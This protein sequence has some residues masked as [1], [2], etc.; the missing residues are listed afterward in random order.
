MH[1]MGDF[2]VLGGIGPWDGLAD[3]MDT[4]FRFLPIWAQPLWRLVLGVAVAFGLMYLL[5]F[6]LRQTA[7]KVAAVMHTTAKEAMSQPLFYVVLALGI[8]ALLMFPFIPYNTLGED[9]KMLKEVGLDLI[10]VLAIIVG[11]WAASV[12][13]ADEIEGRTA[14]TLLSKPLGRRQMIIG[15]FLGVVWPVAVLFIIF[16]VIFLGTISYKVKYDARESSNPE[17]VMGDC[18]N[19]F[20]SS[21]P[22][23]ALGFMK[24]VVL[25]S[26]SVAVSTRLPFL[27][28]IVIVG[29]IYLLGHL[30]PMLSHSAVRQFEPVHFVGRFLAAVLPVL[31]HFSIDGAIAAGV[32]V[33][34]SYLGLA[35]VYALLYTTVAMLV[36]LLLFE[37]RDLA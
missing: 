17:P 36:A 28:N 12:S 20:V 32:T 27:P 19:E 3:G 23:L 6:L 33:P 37:D 26:I 25:V 9:T 2:I 16:G 15:K 24:V 14:L 31:D 10:P 34:W 8:F 18:V 11:L 30:M 29:L 22:G 35:A 21:T 13:I 7:P 5:K 1:L 4:F